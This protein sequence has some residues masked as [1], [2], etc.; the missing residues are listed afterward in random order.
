MIITFETILKEGRNI[1]YH[2]AGFIHID[3]FGGKQWVRVFTDELKRN[4]RVF[5]FSD[6]SS[7]V[8]VPV[9]G[10]TNVVKSYIT[11]SEF[12]GHYISV[13][14]YAVNTRDYKHEVAVMVGDPVPDMVQHMFNYQDSP[15]YHGGVNSKFLIEA[16]QRIMMHSQSSVLLGIP[17]DHYDSLVPPR[18]AIN[19]ISGS[20][21]I[22]D[23]KFLDDLVPEHD[24][25][26]LWDIV[27]RVFDEQERATILKSGGFH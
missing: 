17:S 19:M 27:E 6:S 1:R 22:D 23:N 4:N 25:S 12:M 10:T 3:L 15:F 11:G 24:I 18:I 26:Y 7:C 9:V 5:A 2:P 16:H 14:E 8:W 20:G 13:L 21:H